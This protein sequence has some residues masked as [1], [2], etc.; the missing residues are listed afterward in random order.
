M[1]SAVASSS[2]SQDLLL[3]EESGRALA[4]GIKKKLKSRETNVVAGEA[5]ALQQT[6]SQLLRGCISTHSAGCSLVR[7]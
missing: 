7:T 4:Q 5:P 3:C 1:R 2:Y 6:V